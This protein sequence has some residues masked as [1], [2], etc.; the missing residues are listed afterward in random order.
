LFSNKGQDYFKDIS[1]Y[2]LGQSKAKI[3]TCKF[4][5]TPLPLKLDEFLLGRMDGHGEIGIL[6]I[7]FYHPITFPLKNGLLVSS[8]F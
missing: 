6:D 3:Q 8:P 7:H 1:E 2:P 4:R 5:N